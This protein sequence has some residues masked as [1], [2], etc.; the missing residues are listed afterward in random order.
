MVDGRSIG[1][2]ISNAIVPQH[3]DKA[4]G[5]VGEKFGLFISTHML[6]YDT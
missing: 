3:R 2:A 5:I 1:W 6:G 4:K